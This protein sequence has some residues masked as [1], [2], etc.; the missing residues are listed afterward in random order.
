MTMLQS[1]FKIEDDSKKDAI[2]EIVSDKYC[3]AI[4]DSVMEKPKS[5]IEISAETEISMSSIYRKI[6]VLCDN[7]L[8][9]VSGTISDDGKK[10]FLY[11][12]KIK[13][14]YAFYSKDMI[15]VEVDL[16]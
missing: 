3:R 12:S 15:K 11:K 4:L 1:V 2:L 7:K 10:S 6:Q 8:L 5:V 13:S 9:V 16:N 14:I